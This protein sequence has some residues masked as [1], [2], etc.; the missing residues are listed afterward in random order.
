MKGLIVD[1]ENNK[2][3][4]KNHENDKEPKDCIGKWEN[5][6]KKI[7]NNYNIESSI[8]NKNKEA[9]E[10]ATAWE[11]K[12]KNWCDLIE[13][14]DEKVKAV[15]TE[16]DFLLKQVGTVC[17]KSECTVNV[18]KKLTC[19]VKTIFDCFYTY[20]G[21]DQEGLKKKIIQFKE[22][23]NCLK[24][25]EDKEKG[26]VIAC[27]EAYEEKI[28]AICEMKQ[29]VLT[30]LLETLKCANLLWKNICDDYG[31]GDKLKSMKDRLD[32]KVT[33][34]SD[35]SE[36][37]CD[38][39]TEEGEDTTSLKPPCDVK[40]AKPEPEFPIKDSTS[41][42]SNLKGNTYYKKIKSEYNKAE[43]QTKTLKEK[44]ITSK[45]ISDK[46]LSQKNSMT[47]AIKTAKALD[48]GK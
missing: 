19:L 38:D 42:P 45:K 24:D 7:C 46:T 28:S 21:D 20:D 11:T 13:T 3:C 15:I 40:V 33:E 17:E 2:C 43:N 10:N 34:T 25:V 36:E 26:E 22:L 23:I 48:K 30:K 9:Y 18:L 1:K 44:W 16:L 35:N 8:T 29:D 47:D 37:N 31:L 12:L 4:D 41:T 5:E 14:T 39:H 32:G 6:L 27:I